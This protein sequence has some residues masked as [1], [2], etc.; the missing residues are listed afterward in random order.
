MSPRKK[1]VRSPVWQAGPAGSTSASSASPSQSRR[2]ALTACVWPEVAPLC[3]SSSRERDHR[4]SSPVSRVRA[5]ASALAWASVRTSP[6]RQ[7]WMTTGTRPSASNLISVI[8]TRGSLRSAA[9]LDPLEERL[10]L[11]GRRR[12]AQQVALRQRAAALDEEAPLVLVLDA[13]GHRLHAQRA[14]QLDDR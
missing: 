3:H 4:W 11:L 8:S 2:S 6:D 14:R 5:I 13:L 7:S 10:D 12:A 9:G 1:H